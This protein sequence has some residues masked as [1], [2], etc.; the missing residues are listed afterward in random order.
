MGRG[1]TWWL[2]FFATSACVNEVDLR[3]PP[4]VP[5]RSDAGFDDL[6]EPDPMVP[7]SG[8]P[9]PPDPP[10]VDLNF[11]CISPRCPDGT[12]PVQAQCDPNGGSVCCAPMP[13]CEDLGLF[14]VEPS[15]QGSCPPGL[16]EQAY[17]CQNPAARCCG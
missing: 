9:P 2:W 4:A 16:V 17:P 10:C 3:P 14:C 1:W 13:A 11:F 5:T 6:G 15:P 12:T 8:E 7:D